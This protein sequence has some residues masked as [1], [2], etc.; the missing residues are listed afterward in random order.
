M[1]NS[2]YKSYNLYVSIHYIL[3]IVCNIYVLHN[4]ILRIVG[5]GIYHISLNIHFLL[6]LSP[7][8]PPLK[9]VWTLTSILIGKLIGYKRLSE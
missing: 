8:G 5:I 3:H 1:I 6:L 2:N 7:R 4:Y 9:R